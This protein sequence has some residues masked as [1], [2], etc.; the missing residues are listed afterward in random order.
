MGM[1]A[2]FADFAGGMG[3][4]VV[5]ASVMHVTR[6][7]IVGMGLAVDMHMAVRMGMAMGLR[8]IVRVMILIRAI[9]QR[10]RVMMH[11]LSMAMF[12]MRVRMAVRCLGMRV[13]VTV[14]MSR[15]QAVHRVG[16]DEPA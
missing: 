3:V 10:V 8:L 13:G 12:G 7:V 11:F 5:I 4:A 16:A 9:V 1:A 15:R 6:R 2:G 14:R